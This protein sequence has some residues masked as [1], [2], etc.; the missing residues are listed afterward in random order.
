MKKNIEAADLEERRWIRKDDPEGKN[1]TGFV[2]KDKIYCPFCRPKWWQFWKKKAV[3]EIVFGNIFSFDISVAPKDQDNVERHK[4]T[5]H[6]M[7]IWQ[8]CPRCGYHN[9]HGVPLYRKE[10]KERMLA[11][12]KAAQESGLI[13][14]GEQIVEL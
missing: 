13:K 3:M 4:R 1:M 10:F 6:A 5:S 11:V 2:P 12:V 9:V 7:D 8:T 14:E